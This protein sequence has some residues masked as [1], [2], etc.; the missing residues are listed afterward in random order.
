MHIHDPPDFVYFV[1]VI[2]GR[3]SRKGI[4]HLKKKELLIHYYGTDFSVSLRR[5]EP[6]CGWIFIEWLA[7]HLQPCVVFF[8]ACGRLA[9]PTQSNYHRPPRPT[10]RRLIASTSRLPPPPSRL[11]A[12]SPFLRPQITNTDT[13]AVGN[14]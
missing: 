7:D 13:C 10:A 2:Y 11:T 3:Q 5:G 4:V 12:S 1:I 6:E 14:T 8:D 9:A